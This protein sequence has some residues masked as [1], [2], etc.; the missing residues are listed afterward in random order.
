VVVLSAGQA[1]WGDDDDSDVVP[2]TQN[3]EGP[4]LASTP[5][6]EA[7]TV[8]QPDTSVEQE[9]AT[10][11]SS[12]TTTATTPPENEEEKTATGQEVEVKDEEVGPNDNEQPQNLPVVEAVTELS[13]PSI[14]DGERA[15]TTEESSAGDG[16][17]LQSAHQL[18]GIEQ[19]Q[20]KAEHEQETKDGQSDKKEEKEEVEV[21]PGEPSTGADQQQPVSR[22]T[23]T[24]ARDT[25][26]AAEVP[27][28]S[29]SGTRSA[30]VND[31]RC[32]PCCCG[33]CETLRTKLEETHEQLQHLHSQLSMWQVHGRLP[34]SLPPPSLLLY[35]SLFPHN[36]ATVLCRRRRSLSTTTM[37]A[38]RRR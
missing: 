34:V 27:L 1:L 35:L 18:P 7:N 31:G 32:T 26:T 9:G 6:S 22:V 19:E 11:D 24:H 17:D 3:T 30:I 12:D 28:L 4:R 14:Q 33:Q 15:V 10:T 36:G 5:Q 2:L 13:P 23:D 29:S 20:E 38:C 8:P 37:C 21:S 25:E 16:D